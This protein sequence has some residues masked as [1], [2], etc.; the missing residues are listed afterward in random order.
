[1]FLGLGG[2]RSGISDILISILIS[3]VEGKEWKIRDEK[4]K[5]LTRTGSGTHST[6]A[7]LNDD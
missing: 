7:I 6:G 2:S 5:G 4:E 3:S 1:M